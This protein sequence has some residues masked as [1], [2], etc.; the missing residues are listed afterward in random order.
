MI[1]N[2]K[3]YIWVG[4]SNPYNSI[5]I[6]VQMLKNLFTEIFNIETIIL[7]PKIEDVRSII[8]DIILEKKTLF[9][10]YGGFDTYLI[11][12][13]K[14]NIIFV[15]HNITPAKYF[16]MTDPAVAIRSLIGSIQM[17]AIN[18]S[19]KW[20]TMSKY[21][22]NE[23][24][25]LGFKDVKICP[26]II[27]IK[28]MQNVKKTK[29]VSLLFVGRIAPNKNCINLLKQVKIFADQLSA[30]IE[31]TI[32]GSVKHGCR[33]GKK[34]I[35]IYNKLLNH[36]W[37]KVVWRNEIDELELMRLY[38]QSWLY[39]SMSTHEGFG[40]PACESIAFGTPALYL[41]CGGQESILNNHGMVSLSQNKD[42]HKH[43]TN[44]ISNKN[45]RNILLNDQRKI[46]N[47]YFVPIVKK[48]IIKTYKKILDPNIVE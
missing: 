42:F 44:L 7:H 9:W 11:G 33:Y 20:I 28:I 13:N 41:E 37:L 27:P 18:K 12:L 38:E 36:P 14:K 15:Y 24:N 32:I 47:K 29:H 10:H 25:Q 39:V 43:L 40:V 21:N 8:K 4:A 6:Q 31:F 19:C 3:I 46:V 30:P 2:N 16:W 1:N 34:F 17:L 23:L 48:T 45:D 26:N 35:M 5:F 22:L